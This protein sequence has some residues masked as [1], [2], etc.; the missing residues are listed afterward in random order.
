[1]E[2]IPLA[3][4]A[5]LLH[6]RLFPQESLKDAKTLD[7]LA[8]ALSAVIALYV[9]DTENGALR[10]VEQAEIAAGRFTRG[11]MR[12]EF[13]DRVPLR[14]LLVS[15]AEL[16]PAIETIAKDELVAARVSLALRR[17]PGKNPLI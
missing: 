8:V 3:R 14:F 15:R 6:G 7:L 12:L 5:A 16:Y 2:F 11:A 13:P 17:Q 9:R 4:A 1:M 10:A